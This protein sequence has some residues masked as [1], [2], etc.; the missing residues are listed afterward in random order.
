MEEVY[1]N[2]DEIILLSKALRVQIDGKY[3]C[4]PICNRA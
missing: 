2:R 1:E 4:P 3:K